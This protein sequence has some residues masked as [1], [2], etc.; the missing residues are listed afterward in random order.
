MTTR[1]PAA[2]A[3]A[4]AS[5]SITPSCIQT[6]LAPIARLRRAAD[7]GPGLELRQHVFDVVGHSS[8]RNRAALRGANASQSLL[9]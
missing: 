1:R 7:D 3:R 4:A 8:A 6:A 2:R 9:K 5:W